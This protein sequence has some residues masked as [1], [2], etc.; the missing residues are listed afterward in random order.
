MANEKKVCILGAESKLAVLMDLLWSKRDDG[1][2]TM[3]RQHH[4][5]TFGRKIT[6]CGLEMESVGSLSIRPALHTS[7]ISDYPRHFRLETSPDDGE[8]FETLFE[9]RINDWSDCKVKNWQFEPVEVD[10]IRLVV[11]ETVKNRF[12]TYKSIKSASVIADRLPDNAAERSVKEVK[13]LSEQSFEPTAEFSE[14]MEHVTC[15][16]TGSEIIYSSP[17]FQI[18]FNRHFAQITR[19]GWD[20]FGDDRRDRNLLL[21]SGP[22]GGFPCLSHGPCKPAS[23]LPKRTT[24]G[25]VLLPAFSVAQDTISSRSGGGALRVTG[26]CVSYTGIKLGDDFECDLHFNIKHLGFTL[27]IETRC[28]RTFKTASIAAL[29]LPFNLYETVTAVLAMPEKI[30]PAGLTKIPA[31]IHAPDH[32]SL[33]VT[34]I[35]SR[36]YGRAH[37]LR[38][39]GELWF[40]LVVGAK[41]MQCGLFEV[42][43]GTS[44]ARIDFE[45]D[46]IFPF[47]TQAYGAYHFPPVVSYPW[48]DP[49]RAPL[50]RGWLNGLGFDPF[51]GLF[52]NNSVSDPAL[53]SH[54]YYAEMACRTPRLAEGLGAHDLLRC[55]TEH[56]LQGESSWRMDAEHHSI[57]IPS[58][59]DSVWLLT[60]STQ[61]WQWAAQWADTIENWAILLNKADVDGDGLVES[62][63]SGN[64]N[65]PAYLGASWWD[66]MHSGHI[67][68]FNNALAYRCLRRTSELLNRLG[69]EKTSAKLTEQANKLAANY[70]N[71]LYDKST[72]WIADW[73]S[74]DG[75][76]HNY[77]NIA[78]NGAA[79]VCGL[80]K[81]DKARKI[82]DRITD[83]LDQIGFTRYDFGLPQHMI[84]VRSCDH[85]I[86]EGFPLEPDGT[87]T[88]GVYMNGSATMSQSY[89][90]LQA[91]Y[92]SGMRRQANSLY[93]KFGDAIRRGSVA[94]PLNSGMDWRNWD[95]WPAGY[96][97]LLVEQ[98]HVL[99]AAITG[100]LGLELT[101]DGHRYA[102]GSACD[103]LNK[104]TQSKCD[105]G[106]VVGL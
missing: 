72:G 48:T 36:V 93:K 73:R 22:A 23:R 37:P 100:Y 82:L 31:V 74:R 91:L 58:L 64:S 30:G 99:V 41:P 102:A 88:Y 32:G 49:M 63:K 78:T 33:R 14:T 66:A 10:N 38:Q 26:K 3:G 19:L 95:G 96:E 1:K 21:E 54:Q 98:F 80:I 29:R 47:C 8:S 79:I 94:G 104:R 68:A 77:G 50:V 20:L 85:L 51:R 12:P 46:A 71:A 60:G 55:S 40:D 103:V 97:G 16:V 5:V 45:L 84:P 7:D 69:R 75:Q 53:C 57:M 28:K 17:N 106:V 70:C 62:P 90:F 35:G 44:K 86:G 39:R 15:Q 11:L 92:Q 89:W 24:G 25:D 105:F 76:L 67:E 61:D 52:A 83:K 13:R 81:G 34:T 27:D 101:I 56:Y 43:A 18:G 2:V 87:D 4:W 59:L 42:P 6:V 65:E 9:E